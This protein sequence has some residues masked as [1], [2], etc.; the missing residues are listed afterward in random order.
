M[1]GP[2]VTVA[3][4]AL[5]PHGGTVT[6]VSTNARVIAG[7][8]IATL[9]D[10]FTVAGCA[11]TVPPGVPQPCLLV[12]WTTPAARVLIEGQPPILQ[13][14][15]GLAISATGVPGGPATVVATQPR[16]VMT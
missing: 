9:A 2:A 15:T 5:C 6:I 13:A 10:Q 14:S 11:F 8:P 7:A 12:Q 4:S 1:P 3:A 16:V